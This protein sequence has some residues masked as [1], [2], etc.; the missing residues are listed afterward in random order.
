MIRPAAEDPFNR[1]RYVAAQK[2]RGI[3]KIRPRQKYFHIC[4][5]LETICLI[6]RDIAFDVS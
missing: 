5:S 4:A 3:S 1:S 6:V 2:I